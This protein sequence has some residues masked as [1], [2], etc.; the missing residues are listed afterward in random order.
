MRGIYSDNALEGRVD[1]AGIGF[2]LVV[3]NSGPGF[4][5]GD[6]FK[7]DLLGIKSL[8]G[9]A[10]RLECEYSWLCMPAAECKSIL[11]GRDVPAKGRPRVRGYPRLRSCSFEGS[12]KF[13]SFEVAT[14]FDV[15]RMHGKR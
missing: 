12:E 13:R 3:D 5:K 8:R 1:K 6:L 9:R 14:R 11:M 15:L 4:E 2:S 10:G 7:G